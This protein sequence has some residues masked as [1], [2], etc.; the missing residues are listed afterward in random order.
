MADVKSLERTYIVPLRREWLKAP[1]YKR[2]KRAVSAL[3]AFLVRHMKSEDIRIGTSVNLE[4]W[5]HGIKNPPGKIKINVVKDDKGVVRAEL[6]GAKVPE[7]KA[8]K[9]PKTEGRVVEV[10]EAENVAAPVKKEELKAKET[11]EV[12]PQSAAPKPKKEIKV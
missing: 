1:K 5:K 3:N 4:I 6:F 7:V 11:Q 9:G 10:K 8:E 12:K 2:A